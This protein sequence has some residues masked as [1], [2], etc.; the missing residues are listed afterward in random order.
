[1]SF[2]IGPGP[3][4]GSHS[5]VSPEGWYHELFYEEGFSF[6]EVSYGQ[7]GKVPSPV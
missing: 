5:R 4:L 1:M 7:S 3:F 6:K 2:I